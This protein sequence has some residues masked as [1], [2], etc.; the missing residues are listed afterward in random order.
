MESPYETLTYEVVV[1]KDVVRD[2]DYRMTDLELA[3]I[4]KEY[5]SYEAGLVDLQTWAGSCGGKI[6]NAPGEG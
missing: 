5:L 4:T 6:K 1:E 3:F 2:E